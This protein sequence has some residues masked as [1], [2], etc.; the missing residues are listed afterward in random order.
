MN[1]IHAIMKALLPLVFLLGVLFLCGCS[2]A[3][4]VPEV[5]AAEAEELPVEEPPAPA[6][7]LS[8]KEYPRSTL[9]LSLDARTT[10]LR[11]LSEKL[12]DLPEVKRVYITGAPVSGLMQ[13]VL[14]SSYPEVDFLWDTFLLG[15]RLPS[16]A[17]KVSFA[18]QPLTEADVDTLREN[19]FRLPD[20][21]ELDLADCGLSEER[22][23]SLQEEFP[24]IDIGWSFDLYGVT[25]HT[26]DS[27]IDLSKCRLDKDNAEAF[28]A[29]LPRF[30]HLEKAVL[31][32]CGLSNEELD[33]LNKKYEDIRIVWMVYFGTY[34]L[35]T[36]ATYFI[37]AKFPNRYKLSSGEMD[38]IRY[39]SD[40]IAL[41]LGH[42]EIRDLSFLYDLP[43]LQ[44]LIL[45]E[46]PVTDVTPIGSL[47]ELTYLEMFWT[48]APDISPLINCTNLVDLNISYTWPKADDAYAVLCQMPWL[49]R[50]WY[51][52]CYMTKEQVADLQQRMPDCEMYLELHGEPT[53][54]TWR[55]HPHYFTM[56]DT[57]E[58]YYMKGGT[59]GVDENGQQIYR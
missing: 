45:A 44:Y 28:E 14:L 53:G 33:A 47:K 58:M 24:E 56:R 42:M 23:L 57:F 1:K 16:Y 19:L 37:S 22:L 34:Y 9:V 12:A 43:H 49:E 59:N 54:S 46:D 8:G 29:A 51:C 17:T 27:E 25:V 30:R 40:M 50:L 38:P 41:D 13:D 6:V 52:G 7:T 11:E 4:A 20:L 10:N 2:G 18:G 31:C 39:C 21:Q 35:R 32:N 3:E 5:P 55:E 36:D 26:L 15:K 48:K